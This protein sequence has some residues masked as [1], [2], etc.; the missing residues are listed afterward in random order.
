MRD[1]FLFLFLSAAIALSTSALSTTIASAQS[2]PAWGTT[3]A[4]ELAPPVDE[5]PPSGAH[6]VVRERLLVTGISFLAVGYVASVVWG[7]AYLGSLALG[8][9]SCNDQYAGWHFIPVVG[10]V[11]G[12][13]SGGS[14]IH[15]NLHFEEGLLPVVFSLTQLAGLIMTIVGALGR[16]VPDMPQFAFS[17]DTN[18]GYAT[19]RGSF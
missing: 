5:A 10:P 13:L 8:P 11:L 7:A 19:L 9:L 2:A 6:H 3:G 4:T 14:C 15:D 1:R 12:M 17:A 18:G 16:D